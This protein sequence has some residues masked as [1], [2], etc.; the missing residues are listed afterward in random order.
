MFC[1]VNLSFSRE[2]APRGVPLTKICGFVKQVPPILVGFSCLLL[3]V[4]AVC[5]PSII[6]TIQNE[7]RENKKDVKV[8]QVMK[9][10]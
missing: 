4:G 7:R 1:Q 2:R 9:Q 5:E 6:K 10:L 8:P 3:L